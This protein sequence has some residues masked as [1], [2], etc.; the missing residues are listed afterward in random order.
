MAKHLIVKPQTYEALAKITLPK[1]KDPHSLNLGREIN[2]FRSLAAHGLSQKDDRCVAKCLETIGTFLS[3]SQRMARV[4][5]ISKDQLRAM[6]SPLLKIVQA[7][8]PTLDLAE[9]RG[10]LNDKIDEARN[11][12][13]DIL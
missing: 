10:V 8:C 2:L 9:L 12:P 4:D 3:K 1:V 11:A 6:I 13:D 5:L 7:E